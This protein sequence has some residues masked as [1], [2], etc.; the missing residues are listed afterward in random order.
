VS[1]PLQTGLA[2][3]DL[4]VRRGKRPV[5]E[6]VSLTVAPGAFVSVLGPNGAGKSTLLKAIA[7]LI[8]ARDTSGAI[9]LEGSDLAA[10][11]PPARARLVAYVPQSQVAHWPIPVREAVA[12]GR[13][14]HG[15]TAGRPGPADRAAIERALVV[16]DATHLADRPVTELSGGER[17]RVMLARALAVEAPVLLADEVIAALDPGHQLAVMNVLKQLSETG[18]IVIAALHDLTHAARFATHAIVLDGGRLVA[19]GA[20]AAVLTSDLL[21]Q[22]FGIRAAYL[23]VEGETVVLPW[24]QTPHQAQS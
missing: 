17:A 24:S 7:G 3:L 13:V 11:T 14:P 21:T 6:Q 20:P 18:R 4:S 9:L 10:M 22:V 15:A 19:S 1:A 23:K 16:A 2:V 12:I 8:A 5:L